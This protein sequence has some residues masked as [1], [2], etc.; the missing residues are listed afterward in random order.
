LNPHD[1]H[2]VYLG[3]GANLGQKEQTLAHAIEEIGEQVGFVDARSA[4][5]YSE[6]WGFHSEHQFVNAVVRVITTLSPLQ[7]LNATQ[8]IERLL[9]KR[10]RHHSLKGKEGGS[11][12][13]S[14]GQRPQYQDRPI[15]ID[16]LLY[17]DIKVETAELTIPHPL[18][19]E[20]PFVMEPLQ[21]IMKRKSH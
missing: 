10:G 2:T 4:L 15:D 7:L 1:F 18:M 19:H 5:Y 21:E 14:P 16:I 12:A 17:D 6:P 9:G 8:R 11:P 20:R 3:L 13:P